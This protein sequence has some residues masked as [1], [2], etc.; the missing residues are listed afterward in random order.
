MREIMIWLWPL[1]LTGGCELCHTLRLI[2]LPN[3]YHD[4]TT[5]TI[6]KPTMF[7]SKLLKGD[8][9]PIY[10]EIKVMW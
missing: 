1:L 8:S 3:F 2:Q 4:K 5:Q 9:K 10:N 7:Y 6:Q